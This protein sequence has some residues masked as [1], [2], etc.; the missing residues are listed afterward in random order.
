MSLALP[1]GLGVSAV[2]LALSGAGLLFV[3]APTQAKA[4]LA[5]TLIERAWERTRAGEAQARPWSWADTWPVAKLSAPD[6]RAQAIVLHEAGGEAM[7]FGPAWLSQTAAPGAPGLS[8]IAAHRDTHFAF[9]KELAPGDP[10]ELTRADGAAATF[11]VTHTEIVRHDRS[12]IS[13]SHRGPARLALVT[14][15]PFGVTTPGPLRYVVWAEETAPQR[16]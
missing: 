14:C 12:G 1:V 11:R 9:L 2:V 16:P 15:W 8:V 7:A 4:A 13:E 3:D 6:H 10:V 5:D